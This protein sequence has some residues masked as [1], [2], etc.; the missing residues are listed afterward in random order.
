MGFINHIELM[1]SSAWFIEF[2]MQ[3]MCSHVVYLVHRA[4]DIQKL[5]KVYDG[6]HVVHKIYHAGHVWLWQECRCRTPSAKQDTMP[7]MGQHMIR[8]ME[9]ASGVQQHP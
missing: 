6:L 8:Q 2:M 7:S 4:H 5:H 9:Y 1:M 3:V